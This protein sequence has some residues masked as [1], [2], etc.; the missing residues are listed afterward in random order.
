MRAS[1]LARFVAT[2]CLLT[3]CSD[4]PSRIEVHLFTGLVPGAEFRTVETT[5]IGGSFAGSAG[6]VLDSNEAV[7]RLGTDYARGQQAAAFDVSDGS[8][9]IRVRLLR[10]TGAFLVERVMAVSVHGNVVLPLHITRDCVGV[11]CPVP[12][13]SAA[14]ST[15]LQGR[16]VDPRCSP[17]AP[18]FCPEI[19]FCNELSECGAVS[20]CAEQTCARG[21]CTPGSATDACDTTQWCNPDVG[22]GCEPLT[23]VPT[24]DGIVCGTICVSP[25]DPC[26]FGYWDCSVTDAPVCAALQSRPIGHVCAEGRVC[27]EAADCVVPVTTPPSVVVNPTAGLVTNESGTTA[28]FTVALTTRPTADVTIALSSSNEGEGTVSPPSVTLTVE[29]WATAHVVTVTGADDA[30]ADGNASYTIVTAAAV[31]TDEDY[32]G[33]DAADVSAVNSDD[34]TPGVTVSRTSGLHTSED[35]SSDTFDITLNAAPSAG[36]TITVASDNASE[37]TVS[38]STL[39]FTAADFAMPHT[40]TVTGVD[41]A[42]VDGDQGFTVVTSATASADAVYNG[43]A[44]DDA[45]ATNADDDV[46]SVVVTPTSGLLTSEVG[47]TASFTLVLT[48]QPTANVTIGLTSTNVLEGTVAPASVTFTSSNWSSAQMVTVTGV[49]DGVIDGRTAYTVV[50]ARH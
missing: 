32:N 36:V 2:L 47:G 13:G 3:A 15:C 49:D 35:G 40:V 34:E 37:G 44:V 46:A 31:S 18:E 48:S 21:V 29:D 25:S 45:T 41:D 39:T 30:V 17:D 16:C 14:L 38:P 23:P 8:Y 12:G 24:E 6:H 28:T 50:T 1:L 11:D 43:L 10:P 9:Q 26:R 27:D 19:L 22:A 33:F 7:A 5:L 20:E 4:A 42:V